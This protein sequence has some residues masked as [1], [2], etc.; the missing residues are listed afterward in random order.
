M[1]VPTQRDLIRKT[2]IKLTV[3]ADGKRAEISRVLDGALQADLSDHDGQVFH[4]GQTPRASARR[5]LYDVLPED[6]LLVRDGYGIVRFKVDA[7]RDM[8]IQGDLWQVLPLIPEDALSCIISDAPTD[9]LEGHMAV[10]TTTRMVHETHFKVRNLDCEAIAHFY[11]VLKPGGYLCLYMPPMQRTALGIWR[12]VLEAADEVGFLAVREVV[13]EKG[14]TM[15]Y[16]WTGAHE[17][18]LCFAKGIGKKQA[19]A[20]CD[21]KAATSI[22]KVARLRDEQRTRY[23]DFV[24]GDESKPQYHNTEKPVEV[25]A[26]LL[27]VAKDPGG[28]LLDAFTGSGHACIAAKK[29]GMDY[30]A[31][32][33]EERAVQALLVPRL[34]R[35]RI[36]PKTVLR[37]EVA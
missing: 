20:P 23:V 33:Y 17:P 15:G 3:S 22:V 32:E 37:V 26:H 21:D 28:I 25:A 18:I 2:A 19:F 6:T 5:A 27:R 9:H 35:A 34:E 7:L 14:R 31:I 29:V 16:R 11:R 10:G 24:E 12:Q 36:G 4:Q 8:V 13:W 1:T 30:L